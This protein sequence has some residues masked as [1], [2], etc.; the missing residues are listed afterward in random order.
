[1]SPLEEVESGEL[2]SAVIAQ[3]HSTLTLGRED[4]QTA[5]AVRWEGMRPEEEGAEPRG[6]DSVR[7]I[8][9]LPEVVAGAEAT[10]TAEEVGGD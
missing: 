2:M 8:S 4:S 6:F 5:V 1:M 3:I 7:R 9:S 10:V